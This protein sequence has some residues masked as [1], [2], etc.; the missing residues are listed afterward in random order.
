MSPPNLG[1]HRITSPSQMSQHK[2]SLSFNHHLSYNQIQQHHQPQN[3]SNKMQNHPLQIQSRDINQPAQ[4]G[5]NITKGNIENALI[6]LFIFL[7]GL[8]QLILVFKYKN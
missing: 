8:F 7:H 1:A 2:R 5:R 3:Q 6:F 4:N